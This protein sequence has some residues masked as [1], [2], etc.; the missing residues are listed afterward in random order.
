MHNMAVKFGALLS[1][2]YCTG[3]H[4]V[5]V[6]RPRN[7]V[8]CRLVWDPV[9]KYI[10]IYI[11]VYIII[12]ISYH[13]YFADLCKADGKLETYLRKE[14]DFMFKNEHSLRGVGLIERELKILMKPNSVIHHVPPV[15]ICNLP[16][17][18]TRSAEPNIHE[19]IKICVNAVDCIPRN[20]LL[21]TASMEQVNRI[22]FKL[23]SISLEHTICPHW[24]SDD[25]EILFYV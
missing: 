21:M 17:Y 15:A 16:T 14:V 11:Y 23:V 10:Y 20:V 13:V 24:S 8:V 9:S 6:V 19:T 2:R 7:V 22:N 18:A 3:H 1:A 25:W 12:W 5:R 4:S